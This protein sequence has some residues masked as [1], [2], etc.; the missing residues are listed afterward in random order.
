MKNIVNGIDMT[1]FQQFAEGVSQ[2]PSI[3]KARF[4]VE[5]RWARAGAHFVDILTKE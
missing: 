1:E 3:S 5:T 2:D 4:N